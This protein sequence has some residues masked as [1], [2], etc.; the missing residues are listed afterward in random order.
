MGEV[1]APCGFI[2]ANFIVYWAGWATY[3]TLMVVLLLGYALMAIS[4]AFHLN[5][6]Q[7]K[8]DWEAGLWLFPYLVGMGVISWLGGFGHGGI[9]GS[10]GIFKHV[11]VGGSDHLHLY[12]DLLVLTIFSLVIYFGAMHL[13]LPEK[14]VDEY[15][16]DVYPPPVAE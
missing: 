16:R 11:L 9:I 14:K 1:L 12:W 6:A 4:F 2:C 15:V 13:R 10:V 7:P 8:M 5:P 3:S